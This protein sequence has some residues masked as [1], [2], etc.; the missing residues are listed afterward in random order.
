[1]LEARGLDGTAGRG[2]RFARVGDRQTVDIL[3]VILRDEVGHVAAGSRWFRYFCARR[4]L[5]PEAHYFALLEKYSGTVKRPLHRAARRRA[6]FSE[7]EL[8][9]LEELCEKS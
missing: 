3:A 4:G 2:E 6:G 7:H 1:M 9:R 5:E 8:D